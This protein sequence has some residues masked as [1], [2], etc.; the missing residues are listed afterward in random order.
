MR[1][2]NRKAALEAVRKRTFVHDCLAEPNV[3]I[4]GLQKPI[5]IAFSVAIGLRNRPY[6]TIFAVWCGDPSI[7]L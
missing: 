4:L 7:R 2:N 5:A 3:S 6:R 1:G